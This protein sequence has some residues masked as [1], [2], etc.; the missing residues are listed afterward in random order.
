MTTITGQQHAA[1][2]AETYY[3]AVRTDGTDFY[4][5]QVLWDRVGK[6]VR[7]PN[8]GPVQSK[9]RCRQSVLLYSMFPH[10]CGGTLRLMSLV[11]SFTCCVLPY[12]YRIHESPQSCN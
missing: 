2:L 9:S 8:P 5:G 4:S 1:L 12:G 3:K 11:F 10:L 6:I 7:H